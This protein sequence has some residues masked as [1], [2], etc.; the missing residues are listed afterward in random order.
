MCVPL[1][2]NHEEINKLIFM[3]ATAV[4][5]CLLEIESHTQKNEKQ[6]QLQKNKFLAWK[7]EYY[8]TKN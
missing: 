5:V 2:I 6:Q 4:C 3:N 1:F 7:S 8:S